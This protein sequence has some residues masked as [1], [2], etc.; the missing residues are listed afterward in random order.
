VEKVDIR[1]LRF[2]RGMSGSKDCTERSE[3]LKAALFAALRHPVR[4]P[5]LFG[6]GMRPAGIAEL[7]ADIGESPGKIRYHARKL[8]EEGLIEKATKRPTR[9]TV[10][11]IYRT[12][13]PLVADEDEYSA[14]SQIDRKLIAARTVKLAFE[15]AMRWLVS[16][17]FATKPGPAATHIRLFLD[18]QGLQEMAAAYEAAWEATEQIKE[19]SDRRLRE[20][21]ERG[22][23]AAATLLFYE[24]PKTT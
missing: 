18:P 1:H 10:E 7:A 3:E 23:P 22:A 17:T 16:G 13:M 15:E 12:T 21:G 5:I 20:R 24:L 9:G 6:L 2:S 8:L 14:L 19:A 11:T 4:S